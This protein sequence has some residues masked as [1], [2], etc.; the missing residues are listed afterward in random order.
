MGAKAAADNDWNTFRNRRLQMVRRSV[1]LISLVL[2]ALSGPAFA[3]SKADCTKGVAMIK[4]ELA[5]KHP[6][7]VREQLKKAL[8]SAE[9]EVVENDWGECLD[10]VAAA[11]KAISK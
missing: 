10:Y 7:A 4:A 5:K 8:D 3:D 6:A 1:L 11:R 9:G 2:I